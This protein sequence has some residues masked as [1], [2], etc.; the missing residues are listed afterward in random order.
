ML[1]GCFED[2]LACSVMIWVCSEGVCCALFPACISRVFL[3]VL[4]AFWGRSGDVLGCHGVALG[5]SWGC[6]G[7]G[8]GVL[9]G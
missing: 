3:V 5:V 4:G 9:W 2:D 1:L 7:S 8:S 6:S